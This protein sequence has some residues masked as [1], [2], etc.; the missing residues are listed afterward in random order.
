MVSRAPRFWNSAGYDCKDPDFVVVK[1]Q[2]ED[3][4]DPRRSGEE[5]RGTERFRSNLL[6]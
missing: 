3:S 2:P 1:I 5:G 6:R 4:R